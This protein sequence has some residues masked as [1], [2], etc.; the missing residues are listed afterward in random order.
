M[1]ERA[2]ESDDRSFKFGAAFTIAFVTAL[3]ILDEAEQARQGARIGSP[4]GSTSDLVKCSAA[5][6][7]VSPA[8]QT[9]DE[10]IA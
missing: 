9:E 5:S 7:S 8:N 4:S 3:A 1:L 6:V 10:V 2:I